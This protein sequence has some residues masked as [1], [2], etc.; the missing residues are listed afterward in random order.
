MKAIQNL[1]LIAAMQAFAIAES[2]APKSTKQDS[3]GGKASKAS[4]ENSEADK[5]LGAVITTGSALQTEIAKIPGSV[6]I[7]DSKALSSFSNGKVADSIKRLAGVRVDNDTS[8]NPRPKIKIRGLNYGTLLLLDG[9]ILSDLEGEARILNQI[10]L[11]E[12]ER[13]ELVRGSFASLYGTGAIGGVVNFITPLP[14]KL[15]VKGVLGYGNELASGVGDRNVVRVY[16]SVGETFFDKKLRLRFSAGYT[17]ASL[18]PSFPTYLPPGTAVN[19]ATGHFTD[20]AGQIIIGTGGRRDTQTYD[21]RLK[22]AYELGE[23]D[24]LQ[25]TLSFSNHY[26]KFKEWESFLKDN[27]GRPTDLVGGKD[28]F[29][30]SGLGGIGS[31][32]HLLANLGY[33]HEFE[34]STLKVAFSSL[35]LFSWWQDADIDKGANR[36]GG[37]GTTQDTDSSSN[38]LD[39]IYK[40]DYFSNH[41]ITGALQLRYYNIKQDQRNMDN[42]LDKNSRRAAFRG[43]GNNAFIASIYVSVDSQWLDS[44]STTAGLRY[45]FWQNFG[46]YFFNNNAP[47]QNQNNTSN[48]LSVFS[49]KFGINYSPIDL[50]NHTLLLRAS[51]GTG[52]RMPTMRDKYQFT[53]GTKYWDIN[54]NLKH[55]Q[56]LSFDIGAE[57]GANL[58]ILRGR[59]STSLYYFQIEMTDMIYRKGSGQANDPFI[60][61]NAGKGRIQGVECALSLPLWLPG[62]SLEANY[63]F[64]SARVL[65]NPTNPA[66]EGKQLAATPKHS[67]NVSLLLANKLGFYGSIWVFYVPAFFSD[68]KNSP[69]LSGTYG[70]YETQFSLNAKLGY[71]FKNGLDTSIAFNNITNYRYYDY[72]Q[73]AG[74]SFFAQL[75]YRL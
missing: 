22:A 24:S 44:L 62:L 71:I 38:Y 33:T 5:N 26:Y 8:F 63:A 4:N 75:A 49:P 73:V 51:I 1:L 9:V 30:G 10:S 39:V 20:K 11:Y 45:D 72:Y 6:S 15:E 14:N 53:H 60:N 74:A 55:E 3:Q 68:D 64:T 56:A 32:S 34:D 31:Y 48:N 52:F 36:Y 2:E 19:D 67:L 23:R 35:S 61:V 70:Y 65:K 37:P 27:N 46:G 58:E 69:P 21:L 66:T 17:R 40:N 47:T 7:V 29:V 42:W 28:Q 25:A 54:Q 18:G 13:V 12:V 57:Y 59:L 41:A 50:D 16:A 43:F